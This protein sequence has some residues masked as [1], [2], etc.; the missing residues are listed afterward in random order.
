MAIEK[1][2]MLFLKSSRIGEDEPDLGEKLMESYLKMLLES[3]SLPAKIVCMNSA[4]FLTTEG[5]AAENT[6]KGFAKAGTEILSCG[7]CLDYYNRR[8]KLLIGQPTDMKATVKA[9][10]NFTK[11]LTP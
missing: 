1:D 5:S 7:T 10:L 2:L 4:V 6:L 3:G 11:I 9:M 8:D